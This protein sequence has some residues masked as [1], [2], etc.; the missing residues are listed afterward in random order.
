MSSYNYPAV[1]PSPTYGFFPTGATSPNAFASFHQS[2]RDQHAM[3]ASFSSSASSL[4]NQRSAQQSSQGSQSGF[5][6]LV[7]RK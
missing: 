7:S 6:K 4:Q 3:Y 1:P 2:P 5:K